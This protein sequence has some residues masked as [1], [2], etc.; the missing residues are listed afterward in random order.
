M[1]CRARVVVSASSDILSR[2]FG[3]ENGG[4]M[5][6]PPTNNINKNKQ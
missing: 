2:A 4:D 1:I 3:D 5:G 6:F